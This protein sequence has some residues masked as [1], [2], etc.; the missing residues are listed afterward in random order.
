MQEVYCLVRSKWVSATPEEEVRQN[1]LI[2]MT[3]NLGYSKDSLSVE[4]TL[5]EMPHLQNF[6]TSHF[7]KR[8]ADL[9]VWAA[10]IHPDFPLYPL[11]MIECKAIPLNLKAERQVIGYNQFLQACFVGLANQKEMRLGWFSREKQ[12]YVFKKEILP[13][14]ILMDSLKKK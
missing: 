14:F 11:L 5:S 13:Y 2:H 8:R 7:P 1:L 4:M 9:I 3:K 6:P 10:G 12:K